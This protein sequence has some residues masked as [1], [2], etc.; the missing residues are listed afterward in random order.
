MTPSGSSSEEEETINI[1]PCTSPGRTHDAGESLHPTHTHQAEAIDLRTQRSS[2][3]VSI[4]PGKWVATRKREM[5]FN[6]II[7]IIIIENFSATG[8][9]Y[10]G[11]HGWPQK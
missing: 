1:T 11:T 6:F 8:F 5:Q 3:G 9:I 7:I 4:A 10:L 2:G